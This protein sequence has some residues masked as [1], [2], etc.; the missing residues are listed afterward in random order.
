MDRILE[1]L[2]ADID[3]VPAEDT[4]EDDFYAS[5]NDDVVIKSV[6]LDGRKV[7]VTTWARWRP[8]LDCKWRRNV[9]QVA[10]RKG[11]PKISQTR[12]S[13]VTLPKG[14]KISELDSGNASGLTRTVY[15][16]MTIC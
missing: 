4:R 15:A 10:V 16:C 14:K 8:S 1:L 5:E 6:A 3:V 12:K 13:A 7:T 2:R 9:P 11:R